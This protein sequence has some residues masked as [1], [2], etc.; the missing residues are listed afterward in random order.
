MMKDKDIIKEEYNLGLVG[1]R[2]YTNYDEFC[3]VVNQIINKYGIPTN[4]IS[5]GHLD[6]YG[7]IK[8]G[9]DTLAYYYARDNN[10]PLIE[11]EAEWNTYGR[12][13]GPIR[14]KLIVNDSNVILAFVAPTS[15]GT[16]NTIE[17]AKKNPNISIYIYNIA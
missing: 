2:Q 9:A 4:I 7:R 15:S 16:L 10:I 11:H 13:A 12:A 8:P 6:R 17:L 14:N 5:G 1:S 3:N